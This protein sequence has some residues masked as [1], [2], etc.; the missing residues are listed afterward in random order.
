MEIWAG[1]STGA[2]NGLPR[3]RLYPDPAP[4]DSTGTT[5]WGKK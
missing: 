4:V 5:G 3:Y 1:Q 2:G